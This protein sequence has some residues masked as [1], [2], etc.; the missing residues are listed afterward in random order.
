MAYPLL[1][2]NVKS[3]ECN[4]GYRPTKSERQRK[5]RSPLNALIA[6]ASVRVTIQTSILSCLSS[7]IQLNSPKD[8][9]P[10]NGEVIINLPP[11]SHDETTRKN[12]FN[13]H[14]PPNTTPSHS[15][16]RD[17]SSTKEAAK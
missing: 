9:S 16:I 4:R 2:E 14:V 1:E 6:F 10:T 12:S 17:V 5:R 8:P 11:S 13:N 7:S 3:F 15:P